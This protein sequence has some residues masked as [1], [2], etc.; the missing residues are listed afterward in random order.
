MSKATNLFLTLGKY[1]LRQQEN[2]F[3][4]GLATIFNS[5]PAFRRDFGA[6]LSSRRL[7]GRKLDIRTS[8]AKTQQSSDL[9]HGRIIVDTEIV[10][11][12]TADTHY[13]IEAK[14][15]QCLTRSQLAKYRQYLQRRATRSTLV[16]LTKYEVNDELL[17]RL[18][19]RTI[20]LTWMQ[21]RELCR[22]LKG[23]VVDR[24]LAQEFAEML[25]ENDIPSVDPISDGCWN[26]LRLFDEYAGQSLNC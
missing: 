21:L 4:Q 12:D 23:S 26:K 16:L 25:D 6:L 7:D 22:K 19:K 9:G 17:P 15:E 2:L 3:T 20:W 5:S 18:P 24:F 11:R 8:L 13:V 1:I 14:V 10:G